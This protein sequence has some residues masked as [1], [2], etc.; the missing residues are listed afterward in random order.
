MEIKRIVPCLD[1]KEG[2]VVKGINFVDLSNVGDPVEIALRYQEQGADEIVFLDITA[3]YEN[4]E[5]M[6]PLIERASKMLSI[7]LTLGG[8]MKNIDD[9]RKAIHSGA[10]RVSLNSAAV[11]N[12]ELIRQAAEEFGS[13][14]VVAAIDGKAV[15]G[16]YR[17][18]VRGGRDNTGLDLIEWAKRCEAL[19]AGEILLTSMDGDGTQ[20]GYDI[21]MTDAVVKNVSIPVVASGGCGKIEDI[22][23]VF[24]QTGC[25]A[26]LAASLLH[27][28]KATVGEIKSEVERNGMKCK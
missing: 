25:A 14:R 5:T 12:P 21:G 17:V 7:P 4:R 23:D 19:G 8:G 27:Y 18:F 13:H 2:K 3:T 20:N 9:I 26:A 6:F 24:K 15:D 28:G 22:V 16:V 11:A 10:A 1:I